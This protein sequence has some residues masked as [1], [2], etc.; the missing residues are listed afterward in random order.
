MP[1]VGGVPWARH[2]EPE[3]RAHRSRLRSAQRAKP[4]RQAAVRLHGVCSPDRGGQDCSLGRWIRRAGGWD[5]GAL[6]NP[7]MHAGT[8]PARH[9]ATL[10]ES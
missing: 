7:F 2:P 6:V 3:P 1:V 4:Q 5:N 10:R 8:Y 9:L